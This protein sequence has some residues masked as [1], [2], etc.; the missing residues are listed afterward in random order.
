M[1]LELVEGILDSSG[2]QTASL[3]EPQRSLPHLMCDNPL[4]YDYGNLGTTSKLPALKWTM[5]HAT[6]EPNATT[7]SRGHGSIT[8]VFVQRN[9]SEWRWTFAACSILDK[10]FLQAWFRVVFDAFGSNGL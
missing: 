1:G 7:T 6:D 5:R 10:L 4:K 2:Y 3:I 9:R 8:F